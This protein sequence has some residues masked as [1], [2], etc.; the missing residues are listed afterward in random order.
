MPANTIPIFVKTPD[1]QWITIPSGV[2]GNTAKDG[3]GTTYTVFTAGA[4]GSF[5]E[6]IRIRP[7]GTN[8]QT[9]LRVFLNNGS[10]PATATNNSFFT[11]RTIPASTNSETQELNEQQIPLNIG[12][13]P[14]QRIL[15][16][17]PQNVAA[18]FQATAIGGD[19]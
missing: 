10:T 7:L 5:V 12:L 8:I 11:E 19:Y 14:G 3:T 1:N 13:S 4:D 6:F 18:G 17:N 2:A 15:I 9:V 16:S